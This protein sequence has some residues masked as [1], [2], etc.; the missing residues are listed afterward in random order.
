MS[1]RLA[2]ST[3][4]P[5]RNG[6]TLIE[7]LVVISIISLLVA[8]LLPALTQARKAAAAAQCMANQRGLGSALSL[9]CS[10]NKGWT[11]DYSVTIDCTNATTKAL[12]WQTASKTLANLSWRNLAGYSNK[13]IYF[14][15]TPVGHDITI[16]EP[17]DSASGVRIYS[18]PSDMKKPQSG[19]VRATLSYVPNSRGVFDV[20]GAGTDGTVLG[21]MGVNN[22]ASQSGSFG[23]VLTNGYGVMSNVENYQSPSEFFFLIETNLEGSTRTPFYAV[24]NSSLAGNTINYPDHPMTRISGGLA[25]G[26]YNHNNRVNVLYADG[27]VNLLGQRELCEPTTSLTF[28]TYGTQ[29]GPGIATR[30]NWCINRN[31]MRLVPLNP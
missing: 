19:I 23:P 22:I 27:H 4:F 11:P 9:Y 25:N 16:D 24:A 5:R 29:A 7:L 28:G 1:S 26:A 14:S 31:A 21:A 15:Y 8:I 17:Y 20:S 6:F 30:K 12:G 2:R 3:A 18:C 10:D 13:L